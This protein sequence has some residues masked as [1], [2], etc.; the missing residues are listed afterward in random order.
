MLKLIEDLLTIQERDRRLIHLRI[1]RQELPSRKKLIEQRLQTARDMLAQA[2]NDLKHGQSQL[3]QLEL[4]TEDLK[5]KIA[6]MRTQQNS[7]KTN[8]EYRILEREIGDALGRIRGVEDRELEQM[9]RIEALR[10][11]AERR[12]SEL[13]VAEDRVGVEKAEVDRM[14]KNLDAELSA[15]EAGRAEVLAGIPPEWLARYE[16]IMKHW[17]DYAVVRVEHGSCGGCHMKL[18]PQS[19]HDTRKGLDVNVCTFCGRLLYWME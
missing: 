14:E 12:R 9:E 6:R 4:E 11:D 16:R 2:E 13:A 17:G 19:I 5:Q 18:Q 1:E 10:A 7:V 3:K 15:L 8:D